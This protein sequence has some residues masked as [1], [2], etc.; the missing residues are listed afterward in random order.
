MTPSWGPASI[1]THCRLH[2]AVAG[3]VRVRMLGEEVHAAR[4]QIP[5]W[6]RRQRPPPQQPRAFRSR[7]MTAVLLFA[8]VRRCMSIFDV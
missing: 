3:R 5:S 2:A 6:P 7:A 8:M 4:S 1:A